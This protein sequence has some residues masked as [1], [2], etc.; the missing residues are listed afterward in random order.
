MKYES[1]TDR[2]TSRDIYFVLFDLSFFPTVLFIYFFQLIPVAITNEL[3][4]QIW[5]YRELKE[6]KKKREKEEEEKRE[7][8]DFERS[9]LS[10]TTHSILVRRSKQTR[11]HYAT[12][13][14]VKKERKK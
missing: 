10:T 11:F 14:E 5:Y 6:R 4:R 1:L 13:K 9:N 12:W 2:R 7:K 8:R 3:L